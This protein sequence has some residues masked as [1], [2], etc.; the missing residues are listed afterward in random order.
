MGLDL[1]RWL[2]RRIGL[3]IRG[4]RVWFAEA[5]LSPSGR[6]IRRVGSESPAE[7]ESLEALVARLGGSRWLRGAEVVVAIRHP[8]LRIER[9]ELP[10]L[11]T[12]DARTVAGRRAHELGLTLHDP[13][14]T[15]FAVAPGKQARPAWLAACPEEFSRFTHGRWSARGVRVSRFLSLQY[16]LGSLS[17]LHA[18]APDSRG[19]ELRAYLDLADGYS[20][21]VLADRD[22]WLFSRELS[23][24][25]TG[26]P[27]RD[28]GID[29][30][31]RL[32]AE[33]RRTFHYVAAELRM[34]EVGELHLS[35]EAANFEDLRWRLEQTLAIPVECMGAGDLCGLDADF[36]AAAACAIGLALAPET[37]TSNLLPAEAKRANA[38]QVTRR[39]LVV[40][41]AATAALLLFAGAHLGLRTFSLSAQ[42]D[43]L[44]QMW[45]ASQAEREEAEVLTQ[46]RARGREIDHVLGALAKP[47]PP[48]S[49]ALESLGRLLPDDAVLDRAHGAYDERWLLIFHVEFRGPDLAAAAA[50]ASRFSDDLDASPLFVVRETERQESPN[51]PDEAFVRVRIRIA[52]EIAVGRDA[53]ELARSAQE[54]RHG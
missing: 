21:C 50:A 29:T 2:P 41:A 15:G 45:Q 9:L 7:G 6:R 36:D 22:G 47:Q 10:A 14:C 49:R 16:S 23:V 3:D 33:L 35:G 54:L 20:T 44:E 32:A 11:S 25:V 52:T 1:D 17:R 4:D 48:W 42:S 24:K 40:A 34:G 43:S 13:A 31:E 28:D 30:V 51:R 18:A 53:E 26:D 39:R 38:S 8:E 46:A 12:R 37:A 5:V 27:T 19:G